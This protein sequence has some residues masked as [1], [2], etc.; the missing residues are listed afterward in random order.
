[1][2]SGLCKPKSQM[3][4]YKRCVVDDVCEP[5]SNEIWD[6]EEFA[7]HPV[8][9]VNWDQARAFAEWIGGRLPT[10]AEWEKAAREGTYLSMGQRVGWDSAQLL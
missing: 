9:H 8:T 6:Q 5:P 3:R 4:Q 1:M 10:E 2:P 7:Q